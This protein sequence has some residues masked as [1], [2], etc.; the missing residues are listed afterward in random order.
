MASTVAAKEVFEFFGLARE[1]RD[2]IYDETLL[3]LSRTFIKGKRTGSLVVSA[4]GTPATGLALV[5][6]QF[7][8]EYYARS[9]VA[10]SIT[11]DDIIGDA[12]A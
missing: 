7:K 9:A 1:L 4:H 11:I 8:E 12:G 2:Q 3:H 6:R 5:S 10:T